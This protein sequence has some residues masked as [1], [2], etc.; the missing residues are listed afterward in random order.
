MGQPLGAGG[1]GRVRSGARLMEKPTGQIPV[2]R[3]GRPEEL[4]R[5]V[6]FLAADAASYITGQ[7]WSVNRGM[8]I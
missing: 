7:V 8:D 2:G 4:S 5:V 6:H 1:S 3:A